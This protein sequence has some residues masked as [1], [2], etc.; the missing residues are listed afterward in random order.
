MKVMKVWI[1]DILG[2]IKYKSFDAK[3]EEQFWR[4]ARSVKCFLLNEF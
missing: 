2:L 1:G 3:H 4:E